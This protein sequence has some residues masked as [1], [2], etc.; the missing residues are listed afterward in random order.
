MAASVWIRLFSCSDELPAESPAWICRPSPDTTPV[1][2]V[3]SKVPSG[4]PM[5]IASC[6]SWRSSLE[7]SGATGSPVAS[8]FTIARSVSVSMP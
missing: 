4:L 3:F 6:P 1:V 5:A 8:I 7:P 2:T